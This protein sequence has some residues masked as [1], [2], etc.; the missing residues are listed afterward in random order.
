MANLPKIQATEVL[1]NSDYSYSDTISRKQDYLWKK[2]GNMTVLA[3]IDIW[4]NTLSPLTRKNYASA[5]RQLITHKLIEPNQ[6][7]Q[8][9]SLINHENIIDEIKLLTN[10]KEAT[11][12]ARAAAYISFTGYLQRKTQG[13]ISKTIANQDGTAKTFYKIR[14][15]VK[16]KALTIEQTKSFLVN[17]E[18]INKRDALIAKVILQGGKRKSEVLELGIKN[19]NFEKRQICF[20]Q[21]KTKGI[22]KE[23]VITYPETII[24]EIKK[25]I[26]KRTGLVFVTRNSKKIHS[27][28]IDRTF[29]KAG[30]LSEIPFRTTPHVLRA[31]LVTRLK[32][33]KI[34]D[35]DIMKITGHVSPVQLSAYDKTDIAENASRYYNLVE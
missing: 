26:G 1:V 4:L 6:N 14:E 20:R 23:T 9:F 29:V 18:K 11:R 17:L 8:R 32:E 30:Q 25:Y 2:I 7:L 16:T 3:S 19:V 15:K 24:S 27:Q 5:F 28:Q 21:T 13:L 31:T 33:K 10:W 22:L 35:T 34:Q 12:Q